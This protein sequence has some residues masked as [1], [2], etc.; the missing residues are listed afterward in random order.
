MYI[1]I[2][3]VNKSQNYFVS[4]IISQLLKNVFLAGTL[5]KIRMV[6]ETRWLFGMT[7]RFII[8]H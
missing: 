7:L 1:D 4:A 3:T 8:Y 5:N 2:I 6:Y